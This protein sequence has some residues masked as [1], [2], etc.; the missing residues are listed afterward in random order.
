VT[1][2]GFV[3]ALASVSFAQQFRDVST[4]VGLV[5]EARQSWGNPIWGDINN[6]GFLDLIVPTHELKQPGG[7]FSPIQ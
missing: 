6:D 7:P 4:E 2:A 5:M 3:T 1:A